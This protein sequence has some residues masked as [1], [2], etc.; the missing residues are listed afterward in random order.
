MTLR[1]LVQP[2]DC[3]GSRQVS[4]RS[5]DGSG[6]DEPSRS[7]MSLR[8]A[9]LARTQSRSDARQPSSS[10]R[11]ARSHRAMSARYRARSSAGLIIARSSSSV[12]SRSAASSSAGEY[13]DPRR[14]HATRS[15]LGAIAETGSSCSKVSRRTASSSPAGRDPSSSCARTAIRRAS[16]LESS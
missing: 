6:P 14:L 11:S 8:H 1:L 7:R 13:A 3:H 2:V 16:S 12:L 9:S 10:P 15:A 4:G 5:R